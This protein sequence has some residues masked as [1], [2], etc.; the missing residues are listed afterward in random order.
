MQEKAEIMQNWQRDSKQ[1]KEFYDFMQKKV[2][3][4]ELSMKMFKEKCET[5]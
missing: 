4:T 3:D 5:L 1:H 2:N